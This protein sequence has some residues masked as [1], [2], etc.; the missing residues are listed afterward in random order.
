LI[1]PAAVFWVAAKF[2][3]LLVIS[4][5]CTITKNEVINFTYLPE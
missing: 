5:I 4:V 3:E 2:I 1:V